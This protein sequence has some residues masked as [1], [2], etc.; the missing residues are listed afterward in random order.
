MD[1]YKRIQ[2]NNINEDNLVL[3]GNRI[4]DK[5]NFIEFERKANEN[6]VPWPSYFYETYYFKFL[7]LESRLLHAL[8]PDIC[9]KMWII[10]GKPYGLSEI[11]CEGLRHSCYRDYHHYNAID[12]IEDYI[13]SYPED[14]LNNDNKK[15]FAK[16]IDEFK[17]NIQEDIELDDK[18]E[19]Y[20]KWGEIMKL[21]IGPFVEKLRE[22]SFHYD[23][24]GN[25]CKVE[26]STIENCRELRDFFGTMII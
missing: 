25:E 23:C 3:I 4:Y 16:D 26:G 19:K 21:G 13:D 2:D 10:I 20:D 11:Q 5:T 24:R 6:N 22:Y 1:V 7:I 17:Y 15:E 12:Y 9:R 8:F 18:D 14:F